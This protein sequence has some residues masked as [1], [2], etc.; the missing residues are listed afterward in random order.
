M[1]RVDVRRML[2]E[3]N[4]EDITTWQA[5]LEI[6]RPGGQQRTAPTNRQPVDVFAALKEA[7]PQL[8]RKKKQ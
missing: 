2:S 7:F 8:V 1:G 3:I 5:W 4:S 6:R